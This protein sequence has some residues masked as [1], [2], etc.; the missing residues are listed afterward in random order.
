MSIPKPR[1]CTE[2]G[3]YGIGSSFWPGV[4]KVQEEQSE[5]GLVFGKLAGSGGNRD[6]WSGDLVFMIQDEVADVRAS[7]RYLEECNPVLNDVRPDLPAIPNGEEYMKVREAWKLNLYRSWGRGDSPEWWPQPE[8]YGLPPRGKVTQI[9]E[10]PAQVAPAPSFD[11]LRAAAEPICVP[12]PHE[13]GPAN[14]PSAKVASDA[15]PSSPRKNWAPIDIST[16]EAWK[17]FFARQIGKTS[18]GLGIALSWYAWYFGLQVIAGK[19]IPTSGLALALGPIWIG[20][21]RLEPDEDR[22]AP[23]EPKDDEHVPSF[24]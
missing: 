10:H 18:W 23:P 21:A 4:G 22:K 20:L 3:P 6:H 5:L 19:K 12:I 2:P 8:D 11:A 14:E 24:D 17:A 7:L 13:N 16:P 9:T 15:D 1:D